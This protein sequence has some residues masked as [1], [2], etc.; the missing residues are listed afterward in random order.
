MSIWDRFKRKKTLKPGRSLRQYFGANQ[1]RLFADWLSSATRDADSEIRPAL[2]TLRER[3]RDLQ[4]NNDYA[5]RFIQLI[6]TNTIGSDGIRLQVRARGDS[7]ELDAQANA[8]I[9]KAWSSWSREPTIDGTMNM[10]DAQRLFIETVARDGECLIRLVKRPVNAWG[11]AIQILEA[12]RLDE[13]LN[14]RGPNGTVIRMGVEMD[15]WGK[16]LAYKLYKD[17]PGADSMMTPNTAHITIPSSE[18]IH[19]FRKERASQTRGVPWMATAMSRLKMLD[20]YEEAEV[21]NARVS[22]SKMGFFTSDLHADGYV[23]DASDCY[24]PI[25]ESAPGQF[26]Q[27]PPGMRFES[28]DPKAPSASFDQFSRSI[29]RGIASG[30]GVS[31]VTLAND[32][33][34]VNYS[35]IRAG[36]MHDRDHWKTLQQFARDHFCI[37]IY[38][39]WLRSGMERNAFSVPMSRYDKFADAGH[40]LGRSWGWVDP[41]KEMTANVLGLANGVLSLQDIQA[42]YGRDVEELFEQVSREDALSQSFGLDYTF[43]PFGSRDNEPPPVME[44]ET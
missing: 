11:F 8:E 36:E 22:A 24:T 28:F 7:G 3:S 13:E 31:Y 40:F 9:E 37:P 42:H 25:S 18:M 34:S 21:V 10:I 6:Q 23:G 15:E 30:L 35:S 5:A 14:G 38:R 19:A 33:S 17:H 44:E 16:P 41:Q 1:G 43:Q 27:L 2:R 20:S 32:L 12:D 29:L 4:R 39:A 26:E